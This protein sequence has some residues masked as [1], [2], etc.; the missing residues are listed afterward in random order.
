MDITTAKR[1]RRRLAVYLGALGFVMAGVIWAY[2]ELTDSSPPRP[3]NFP[4]W[5]IFMVLCPSSLL[6]IPLI[7]VEPG[8]VDFALMWFVVGLVNAALYAT[9]GIV[10]GKFRWKADEEP[11]T[12]VSSSTD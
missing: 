8:S 4:L 10:V 1:K 9:I 11:H 6:T 3:L 5:T 7:D 12:S 2:S